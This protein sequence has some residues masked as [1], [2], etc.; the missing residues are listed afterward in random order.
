[1]ATGGTPEARTAAR[2]L[3]PALPAGAPA[4]GCGEDRPH[5]SPAPPGTPS[6]SAAA[7][8]ELCTRI[9]AHWSREVLD[10]DTYGDYQSMGLSNRQYEILR[11][12]VDAARAAEK[13]QG[14]DAAAELI[15]RRARDDCA[16]RYRSGDP[17]EGA[18][19]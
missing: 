1:M 15:D 8:E 14:A 6:A 12:V 9:V 2:L 7:P 19:R 17:G 10:G 3:G 13:T 11:T 16:A 18:W 5:A 4:T